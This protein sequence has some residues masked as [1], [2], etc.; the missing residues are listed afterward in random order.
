MPPRPEARASASTRSARIRAS[1]CRS[2]SA[3]DLE[4]E[5]L[6]RVADQDRGRLVVGLVHGRL[7]AAQ[8]V[9]VHGRQVVMDEA[10]AVDA[11]RRRAGRERCGV[12]ARRTSGRSRSTRNGPQALAAA[13]HGVPHRRHRRGGRAISPG[14]TSG[15]RRST[16]KVSTVSATCVGL[17]ES[18]AAGVAAVTEAGLT[19]DEGIEVIGRCGRS[20]PCEID[21]ASAFAG[22]RSRWTEPDASGSRRSAPCPALAQAAPAVCAGS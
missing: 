17:W 4:G 8:V 12:R 3:S 19:C 13:Q 11:A 7:A 6:Q 9:V 2:R 16:R 1:G 22:M 18:P 20:W 10:V 21:R 5:R 15:P 14:P